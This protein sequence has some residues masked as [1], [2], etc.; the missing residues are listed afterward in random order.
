MHPL[1]WRMLRKTL[2]RDEVSKPCRNFVHPMMRNRR[3]RRS[4]CTAVHDRTLLGLG[5]DHLAS[6]QRGTG[7][8]RSIDR[9]CRSGGPSHRCRFQSI[10]DDPRR[11]RSPIRDSSRYRRPTSCMGS[12][13]RSSSRESTRYS[14]A[15]PPLGVRR[16]ADASQHHGLAALGRVPIARWG[17]VADSVGIARQHGFSAGRQARRSIAAME[18][19][20]YE[21][22]RA[23]ARS[24][25]S[26]VFGV[27]R[28]RRQ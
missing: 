22:R 19:P 1:H 12:R 21:S 5:V 17:A 24:A 9:Q 13:R 11:L 4:R 26:L 2:G 18:Q 16:R 28:R 7:G 3:H 6:H 14:T 20:A 23:D 10:I 15:V 27:P 25:R 8:R